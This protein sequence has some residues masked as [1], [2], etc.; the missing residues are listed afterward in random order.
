LIF[1]QSTVDAE[2]VARNAGEGTRL[3]CSLRRLAAQFLIKRAEP[4][5]SRSTCLHCPLG[6]NG[7]EVRLAA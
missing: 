4:F 3:A 5:F 7:E 1:T 2:C 6:E